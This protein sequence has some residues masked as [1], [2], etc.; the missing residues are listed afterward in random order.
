MGRAKNKDAELHA[1]KFLNWSMQ[2]TLEGPLYKVSR[3][4]A[5][6]SDRA[7]WQGIDP[8]RLLN[9]MDEQGLEI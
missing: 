1:L 5:A 4:G 2:L 3:C 6:A 8:S 9:E 7:P